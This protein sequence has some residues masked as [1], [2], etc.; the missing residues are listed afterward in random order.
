MQRGCPYTS[1]AICKCHILDNSSRGLRA[2]TEQAPTGWDTHPDPRAGQATD[3]D[4]RGR[5]KD[6]DLQDQDPKDGGPKD[7]DPQGQ[8]L[9]RDPIVPAGNRTGA[10]CR[11]A[12]WRA[13]PAPHSRAQ[14]YRAIRE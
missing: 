7:R 13:R 14:G 6:Q 11:T 2:D 8:A 12:P 10:R 3:Q 9:D 4:P 1:L 5:A